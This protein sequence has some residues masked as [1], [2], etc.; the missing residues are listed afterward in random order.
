MK[1]ILAI[2][3]FFSVWLYAKPIVTASILPTKYFIEQIAGDTVSVNTMVKPGANPHT[4]EPK[5]D[6]MKQL[7]KSDLFFAI[8]MEYE[9][10]W[11]PK[12]SKSFPKLKI[13]NT[14][15][16][17]EFLPNEDED[18]PGEFDPHV[19]LDPILVKI[20]A[21]NIA[22]ALI[23]Q[24]PKNAKLYK[25]NLEKFDTKIDNLDKFIKKEFKDL[26]NR[27]FIVYH[28]SW[29]Y[30]AKRYNLHQIAIEYEGKEPKPKELAEIIDEAK[31]N[32]VKVI[33][34]APQFSKKSA[35]TIAKSV[36]AKIVEID[37]LPSNWLDGMKKTVKAFKESF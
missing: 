30:F 34:V 5:P 13:I 31:K 36:G 1:K 16:G 32:H 10:V 20:Q 19:W 17:I 27:N 21:K 2:L 37:Q 6:Q 29:G 35:Q 11:L 22:D 8:G 28:P 26:K 12:F 25:E 18:E 24:Y 3:A 7:E 33:F 14:Q 9:N 15:K 4:Y 23:E